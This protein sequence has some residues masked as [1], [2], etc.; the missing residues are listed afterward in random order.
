MDHERYR[1]WLGQ[2]ASVLVH[3]LVL[4]LL[5][6]VLIQEVEFGVEVGTGGLAGEYEPDALVAE[7]ELE[8]ESF[9]EEEVVVLREELPEEI[10]TIPVPEKPKPQPEKKEIPKKAEI[11]KKSV[12]KVSH[13]K[14]T[15]VAGTGGVIRQS[16][17]GYLRNPAPAYPSEARRKRQQG[18]VILDVLLNEKGYVKSLVVKKS[19]GYP[20]LDQAARK[21]VLKWRFR[22]KKIGGVAVASKVYVPIQFDLS[23]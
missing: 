21:A 16:K 19:S 3:L 14:D 12:A 17:P 1:F 4:L 13:S 2:G 5:G 22:P 9:F 7:I 8:E 6:G 11:K 23:Q 10:E 18:R 15:Q 20:L